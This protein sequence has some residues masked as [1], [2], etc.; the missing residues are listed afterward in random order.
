M[1]FL[2]SK[3]KTQTCKKKT[4]EGIKPTGKSKHTNSEYANNVIVLCNPLITLLVIGRL[5]EKSILTITATA[6]C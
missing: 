6:T 2:Q 5:K 4:Y 1:E 3:R